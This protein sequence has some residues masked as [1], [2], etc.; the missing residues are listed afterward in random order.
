MSLSPREKRE[1]W[2]RW[3]EMHWDPGRQGKN[4]KEKAKLKVNLPIFV[5]R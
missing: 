2:Y 3:K 5:A 4:R 1:K